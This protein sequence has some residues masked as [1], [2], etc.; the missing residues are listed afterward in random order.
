MQNFPQ[1]VQFGLRMLAKNPGFT[2]I[3]ILTLGLGIGANTAI[4]SLT[5]QVLLRS[6]PVKD[7]QELVTLHSPGANPGHTWSD[8][9]DGG[10]FSYP[11]YKDLRDQSGQVFSGLL[12]RFPYSLTVAGNGEP[13]RCAGELVSGNYFQVL[14]VNPALG[15]VFTPQDETA[16]GANPVAVLGHGYWMRR[17]GGNPSILNKQLTVNGSVLTVVGVAAAGFNT[18]E[19]GY[20]TDIF[21]PITMK[22]QI[23]PNWDGLANRK[24]QWVAM[25]GRLKPDV[26]AARAQV[27]LAPVF[28]A[29]LESEATELRFGDKAKQRQLDRK[30]LVTS[31]ANGRQILQQD[32]RTPFLSLMGMV[33]LILLIACANLASLL[34]AR[35]EARQR[36]IALRMAL[37]SGRWRL[38]R[39]LLTE[40][41]L[42]AI[43]GGVVGLALASWTLGAFVRALEQNIQVLGLKAH[44]DFRV[45]AFAL[46]TSILTALLF[47]L[48][49]ALR[50]TRTDLQT[51]L[52]DQGTNASQGTG[53]VRL[54]RGLMV[55]QV[56]LTAVLLVAA[57]FFAHSLLN[58]KLQNLGMRVDHVVQ[59]SI[60]PGLNHYST[61]QTIA[62]FNRVRQGVAALPGV[63]GVTLAEIGLFEDSSSNG[64]ITPE[65]YKLGPDEDSHVMRNSVAPGHFAT[66]GIPLLAGREF[67]ESDRAGSPPV[68]IINEKLAQKFFAGRNPVGLH[69]ANGTGNVHPDIEI[70]G[71]VQNSKHLDAKDEIRPTAYSPYL[72]DKDVSSATFYVRTALEPAAMIATLRNAV[73]GFDSNVPA[74]HV[75]QMADQVNESVFA[76]RLLTVCSLAMGLL[77]ALLAAVGLYGVMAYVVTRRTREIGIR[78]ALGAS[79]GNAAGLILREVARMAAVGLAIGLPASFGLGRLIES[80]LY[81]VKAFDPLVLAS[82]T[83]LLAGVAFLAGWLPARKAASV[84]P[85]VALRY[86]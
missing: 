75:R 43:A 4:F 81:G 33:A 29:I 82:A 25:L 57:G 71:V 84:D 13:E 24:D 47:G 41:L 34:V 62:Y 44:L 26:T 27:A 37:G 18:V 73:Q 52:K 74:F 78:M 49:P 23:T 56:A 17:F 16:P 45:L 60:A 83:V 39:Q 7:P 55:S 31:A 58:L 36:E 35:G 11:K 32:A 70:V 68:V 21:I 80:Q 69:I 10:T 1:D 14:E 85:M 48:G 79:S 61:E 50:A 30:L 38:I 76:D 22:A 65:G 64:D 42:L 6:L 67:R 77:A 86:A 51:T 63:R 3:A 9:D 2:I 66:L 12:A 8:G 28:H 19:V 72:Q 5:D 54:R 59:F 53:N 20:T 15:R 40:S 46:G